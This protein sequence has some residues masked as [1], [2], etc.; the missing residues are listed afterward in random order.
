MPY[1]KQE[2]REIFNPLIKDLLYE[3]YQQPEDKRDGI[4]NY[5]FTLLLN[6]TFNEVDYQKLERL[7]GILECCK[8]EL[9]RK[10]IVPYEEI[11]EKENGSVI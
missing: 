11:K 5:I 8:L 1:I 10:K 9:Y 4:I 6:N 7:I 3:L 2:L